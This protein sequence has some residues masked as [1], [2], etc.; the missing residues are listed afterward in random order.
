MAKRTGRKRSARRTPEK[1]GTVFL[2]DYPDQVR[3]IA[4]RGLSD[5]EMAA[6]F[7]ISPKLL[8]SWRAFYPSFD[9]AIRSGR[10]AADAR[11]VQALFD[12]AVGFEYDEDVVLRTKDGAWVET[13]KKKKLGETAAQKYWLN[14]RQSEHWGEKT[15]IGGDRSPGAKPI[16]I[17]D[18][19]KQDVINSILNLISPKP[20]EEAA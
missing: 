18:E 13:V 10:T 16:G 8:E 19:T 1:A 11:V 4:M 9:E 15:Q 12:N 5:T 7:G 6:V 2:P 14:N 3:A 20:D 17:R